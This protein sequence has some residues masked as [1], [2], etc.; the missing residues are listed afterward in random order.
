[1]TDMRICLNMIVKQEAHIIESTLEHLR[2]Y[3]SY[4]V[5]SDTGSTDNTREIITGFFAKHK[6]P[7][8]LVE[9]A[10]EDFG[11]NRTLALDACYSLRKH[12]DYIWV[13]D[14][15]DLISGQITFP[16][17][18]KNPRKNPDIF[19]VRFGSGFTYMRNQIFKAT[20]EWK[21]VGVLHEFPSLKKNTRQPTIKTIEGNYYI[22]SRRLGDRSKAVDK[23]AKDAATL[24][25]GLIKEPKNERYMFYLGQSYFDAGNYEKSIY[26][27]SKRVD[28]GKWFEEVYYSLYKIA[29]AKLKLGKDWS[30]VEKAYMTAWKYLPSRSEPLYEIA[31]H[32]R[33]KEDFENAY[34]YAKL[35]SRIKF[36]S[37]QVLF[38]FKSVYDHQAMDELAICCYNLKKYKE[39]IDT[40]STLIQEKR[41]PESEIGRLN[42][43]INLCK[44]EI[45]EMEERNEEEI[46]TTKDITV[47]EIKY[48]LS[49]GL[50]ATLV[51]DKFKEQILGCQE[52]WAKEG[53]ILNVPVKYF[54]GEIRDKEFFHEDIVHLK[55]VGD[56]YSSA[57]Y[58]QYYGLRYLLENYPS[59]FY[60]IAGSDNY[61][62]IER[63]LKMLEKYDSK[64]PFLIGG[65]GENREIFGYSSH[66]MTGGAGLFLSHSALLKMAPKFDIYI[67]EYKKEVKGKDKDACDVSIC[68]F[69]RSES[70]TLIKEKELYYCD[71]KGKC[72]GYMEFPCGGINY[73]KMSI[74][75]Y[76]ERTDMHLYN[77][78]KDFNYNYGEIFRKF[79][80][81]ATINSDINEHC[82]ILENYAKKSSKI[83]S[84]SYRNNVVGYCFV[85]GLLDNLN[86]EV[87]ELT[88]IDKYDYDTKDIL[89]RLGKIP[90]KYQFISGNVLEY[91]PKNK[92]DII[93]ID[94][95]H[96]YG[97][98]IRELNHYAKYLESGGIFILHD[99]TVDAEHGEALRTQMNLTELEKSTGFSQ[100]ELTTG[101]WPAIERF[102]EEI[103]DFTLEHRYVHN[104]GLTIL[105]KI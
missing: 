74:C 57:T 10:W 19:S 103:S 84:C 35:A 96:V 93:F 68:H 79:H 58:K 14:A 27:Y 55:N 82:Y 89:R 33:E 67:Q 42:K 90:V 85:K 71:W 73:D 54:C 16:K 39:C 49:I 40:Y 63:C 53:K 43:V 24:E 104:H 92:L 62:N 12:F 5:I 45:A 94:T 6:I 47:G 75:H 13:F 37:D 99:T 28:Q 34:K 38:L 98:L 23:Y 21:Y 2:K 72:W 15:D 9:H 56:D 86:T 31:K 4:W 1:M 81:C 41:I 61:V 3:I 26:W 65:H 7:G 60:L 30:E 64:Y 102:L 80:D 36:P 77:Y 17:I 52:T 50:M 91:I 100:E 78:W 25:R 76:M 8:K 88:C 69:A 29:E 51:N 32:Y 20:E 22:D 97:Q 11:T 18:K 66:Y 59:D 95:L 70:V 105:R 48:R 46:A 44:I 87:R 83:L 101:L